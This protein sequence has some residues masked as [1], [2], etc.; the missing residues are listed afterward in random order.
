MITRRYFLEATALASGGLLVGCKVAPSAA[1]DAAAATAPVAPPEPASF[2]VYLRVRN[3]GGIEIVTPQSEM[4]QGVHDGLPRILAEELDA[5]WSSVTVVMPW[6][7]DRFVNPTTKRHRTA[8]SES[9]M[10]YFEPLRRAGAA[11]REMLVAAAAA[12]WGVP[13]SE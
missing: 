12:R 13:A 8:N 2:G 9:T 7:D 4:G 1:P 5:E 11:A 3:D 6:A 10:V